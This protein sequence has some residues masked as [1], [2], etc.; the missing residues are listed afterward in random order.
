MNKNDIAS[1]AEWADYGNG[2]QRV[3]VSN[4][5]DAWEEECDDAMRSTQM[6]GGVLLLLLVVA[7]GGMAALVVNFAI[8]SEAVTGW[9]YS[10][11]PHTLGLAI[12]GIGLAWVWAALFGRGGLVG[13]CGYA[14]LG[15][16]LVA[17]GGNVFFSA[18]Y[19][20]W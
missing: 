11:I 4:M 5:K 14:V 15:V 12:A 8:K 20:A 9:A 19:G 17:L 3:E 6:L 13:R 7:G 2:K 1:K 16:L 10:H 18:L